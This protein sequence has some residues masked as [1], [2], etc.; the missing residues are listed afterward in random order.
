VASDFRGEAA[1]DFLEDQVSDVVAVPVVDRLEMI[2][3]DHQESQSGDASLFF[4]A[5]IL[6]E[7]E[8]DVVVDPADE[9]PA[10]VETG[11]GIV[12]DNRS[13]SR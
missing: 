2:E 4:P 12:I 8:G 5:F 9:K 3:V 10:V 1:G 6:P 13:I 11:Q 7:D